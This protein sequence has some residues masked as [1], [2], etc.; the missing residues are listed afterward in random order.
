LE[1]D[2]KKAEREKDSHQIVDQ[3]LVEKYQIIVKSL[4]KLKEEIS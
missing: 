3:I 2:I 1:E 4:K